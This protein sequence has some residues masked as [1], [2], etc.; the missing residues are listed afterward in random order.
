MEIKL[1]QQEMHYISTV[2]PITGT[3]I[4]DCIE[5][6]NRITFIVEKGKLGKAIGKQAR[7]IKRLE[8]LFRKE[9]RFVEH[10]DDKQQFIINLFKPFKLE[11]VVVDEENNKVSVVVDQRDKGK[12]IG[13]AGKNITIL[14][15]IAKRQ[16]GIEEL[17]VL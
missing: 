11:K 10:D 2:E 13:K 15:E 4:I 5:R 1:T 17:K 12:A 7:N 14:R 8:K 3:P 16:H 6:E 9:V